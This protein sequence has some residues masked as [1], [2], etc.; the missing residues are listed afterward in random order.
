MEKE[1]QAGMGVC[2]AAARGDREGEKN[3]G[4]L[5]SSPVRERKGLKGWDGQEAGV[6]VC[7][8]SWRRETRKRRKAA[9][10]AVATPRT[11]KGKK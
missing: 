3:E 10:V 6:C 4:G 9:S 7:S 2:A 5:R 8:S 11:E 1:G